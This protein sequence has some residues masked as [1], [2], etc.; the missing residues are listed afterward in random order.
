MPVLR[1]VPL[2]LAA[3][4]LTEPAARADD[5]D[6]PITVVYVYPTSPQTFVPVEG[7]A[8]FAVMPGA[9]LP[10]VATQVV[11]SAT[12]PALAAVPLPAIVAPVTPVVAA[13]DIDCAH[14][15]GAVRVVAPDVYNLDDDGDGIGCEPEER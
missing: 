7:L 2:A 11:H 14:F 12:L 3:L 13:A 6:H 8:S 9:P 10:Q 5:A 1:L 15:E 4:A